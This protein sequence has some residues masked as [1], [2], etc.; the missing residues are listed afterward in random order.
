[1]NIH[2]QLS[3]IT[4]VALHYAK[5]HKC[6]YNII[7]HNPDSDAYTYE[8]VTDSYIESGKHTNY[9]LI[10]TTDSILA[11]SDI[12]LNTSDSFNIES[13]DFSYRG[14]SSDE[15][16]NLMSHNCHIS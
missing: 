4:E 14:I 1:M 9:E 12:N 10:N 5:L 11:E 16:I 2:K 15:Y 8:Y 6:N 13:E 7:M 3:A